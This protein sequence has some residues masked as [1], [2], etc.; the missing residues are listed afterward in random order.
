M[1]S[2]P[3]AFIDTE[4][5]C[6]LP[7]CGQA[8]SVRY[9]CSRKRYC[10]R[11]CGVKSHASHQGT[12]NP[13]YDG[14]RTSHPLYDSWLDMRA[15]CKRTTHHAWPRYGGRG[16][17]VCA[18]W[19]GDFWAFVADMGDRPPGYSLDRIDNDGPYAPGNTR[20]ASHSQQQLNRRSHAH[21]G[22]ERNEMGQ[23][24]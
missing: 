8:F 19:D 6:A 5:V 2:A 21:V 12:R 22:R 18:R 23:F 17:A 10:S 14:G 4:R 1:T 7:G 11:S 9:R 13:R 24:T 16:I 3:L 15:R 20:W